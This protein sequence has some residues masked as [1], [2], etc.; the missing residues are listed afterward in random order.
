MMG[1]LVTRLGPDRGRGMRGAGCGM[2]GAG[3][4][5]GRVR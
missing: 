3:M 1:A 2:R 5:N 4:R